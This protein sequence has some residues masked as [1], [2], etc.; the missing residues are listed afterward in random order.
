[1]PNMAPRR[2]QQVGVGPFTKQAYIFKV[3]LLGSAAVGK[4]STAF[5]RVKNDVRE[6]VLT[7]GCSFFTQLVCL[8]TATIKLEI[9]DTAGQ[10]K[11]HSVCHF[12]YRGAKAALL[13]YDIARKATFARAKLW[14]RE[15]EKA[16]LPDELMIVLVGNKTDLTA[17]REVTFEEAEEFAKSKSL[18]YIET[19]AKSNHQ[20]TE[21]F[22]ATAPELL[23]QE[24]QKEPALQPQPW[25][26]SRVDLREPTNQTKKCCMN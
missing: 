19:F 25:K 17:Q 1:M 5:L 22:M 18:I 21:V 23:K 2:T 26:K 8:Q 6:S 12:Y 20:V 15:L 16:F 4:S 3:V 14:L 13:V 9:W 10:E 11:Y 7:V 24:Q